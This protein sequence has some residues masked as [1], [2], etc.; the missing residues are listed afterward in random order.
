MRPRNTDGGEATKE[1][2]GNERVLK[3]LCQRTVFLWKSFSF[4][5][6]SNV[7]QSFKLSF[8]SAVTHKP[9]LS[10]RA[11]V[12]TRKFAGPILTAG[13]NKHKYNFT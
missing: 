3:A 1:T 8:I 4:D 7:F 9:P 6:P 10:A 13:E 5:L 11:Q 2:R 12:Q